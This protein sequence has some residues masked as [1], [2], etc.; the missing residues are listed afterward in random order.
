MVFV[1]LYK[2]LLRNHSIGRGSDFIY[3]ADLPTCTRE[4][5]R[6]FYVENLKIF[7]L[8]SCEVLKLLQRIIIIIFL[9]FKSA[10]AI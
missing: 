4:Y 8:P 3:E 10:H 1:R 7:S 5:L 9:L 2:Q 6:L